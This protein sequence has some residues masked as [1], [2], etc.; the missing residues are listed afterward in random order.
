MP[1]PTDAGN[2]LDLRRTDL[3]R[4]DLRGADL[5]FADFE[6]ADLRFAVLGG[7]DLRDIV[8]WGTDFTEAQLNDV[9]ISAI[10]GGDTAIWPADFDPATGTYTA[11]EDP[12]G[13]PA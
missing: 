5:R 2:R 8:V 1:R 10:S 4:V 7:A 3:R 11:A 9:R 12:H 6:E 13:Q